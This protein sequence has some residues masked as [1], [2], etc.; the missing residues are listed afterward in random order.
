MCV[1]Y[2]SCIWGWGINGVWE[3][4]SN[5]LYLIKSEIVHEYII[6]I[7]KW[8]L[9]AFY[10]LSVPLIGKYSYIWITT[11]LTNASI[12]QLKKSSLK[13]DFSLKS[14]NKYP[15]SPLTNSSVQARNKESESPPTAFG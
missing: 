8:T 1:E 12:F 6:Y 5:N 2:V 15:K 14:R 11:R 7:K 4:K 10:L 9:K 3:G 13:G